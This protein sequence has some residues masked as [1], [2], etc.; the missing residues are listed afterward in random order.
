[1]KILK[2]ILIVMTLFASQF[3]LA[4]T[5]DKVESFTKVIIS[6][7]IETTFVQGDEESV[8]I[9]ESTEPEDKINIEVK[10]LKERKPNH[11]QPDFHSY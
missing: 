9:V 6:P 5:K 2:Y 7:H 11:P 1:M 8:T 4:Q 10:G 3:L